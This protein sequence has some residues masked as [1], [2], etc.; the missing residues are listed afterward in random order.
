MK[1]FHT[2]YL[3]TETTGLSHQHDEVLE[4]SILNDDGETL[5]DTLVKP[6]RKKAW[7]EAAKI[8]GIRPEMILKS[9]SPTLQELLP[10]IDAIL[11]DAENLVIYNAGYDLPFLTAAY[12]A[13]ELNPAYPNIH[14]AMLD[15]AKAYG[16]WD[17]YRNGWKWQKLTVAAR[18][19]GHKWQGQ[20][21]RALADCQATRSV[22]RWLREGYRP[23]K[24]D[25]RYAGY[26]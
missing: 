11:A 18:H 20:A 8:H 6:T 23:G 12:H 16:V 9:P 10:R 14:C 2:V 19:V 13:A 3:D 26:Q 22:W 5:L 7:P 25:R 4:I 24:D 17:N 21:H 15:F 1:K